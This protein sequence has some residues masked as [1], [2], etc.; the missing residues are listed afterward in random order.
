MIEVPNIA[1][2]TV[3]D[4]ASMLL[5]VREQE[6]WDAGHAPEAVHIPL[7]ELPERYVELNGDE[8]ILV[9]CRSGGRSAKAAEFLLRQ[10]HAAINVAGGMLAWQ[11]AEMEMVSELGTLPSVS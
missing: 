3:R 9:I 5:D 11:A 2:D 8:E 7:S 6:E 4:Y 1:V 10:G